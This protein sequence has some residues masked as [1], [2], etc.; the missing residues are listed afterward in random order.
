MGISATIAVMGGASLACMAAEKIAYECGKQNIAN[1]ISLFTSA[2]LG[3]MA[4]G[5]GAKLVEFISKL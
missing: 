1:Y 5:A 2:T 3:L 4:L